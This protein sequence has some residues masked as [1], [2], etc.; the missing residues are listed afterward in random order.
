MPPNNDPSVKVRFEIG[1]VGAET[2]WFSDV[3]AAKAWAG[4]HAPGPWQLAAA[5][6]TRG[7]WHNTNEPTEA[8]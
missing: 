7:G 1:G 6:G 2:Q 4:E 3:L 8:E 5:D